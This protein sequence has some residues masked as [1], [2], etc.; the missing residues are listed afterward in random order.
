MHDKFKVTQLEDKYRAGEV[1][2]GES[3]HLNSLSFY[4]A[5]QANGGPIYLFLA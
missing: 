2:L 5:E 1:L 4:K 3:M